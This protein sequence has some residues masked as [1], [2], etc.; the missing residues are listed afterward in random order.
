MPGST[1]S[2]PLLRPGGGLAPRRKS[3]L[4]ELD[5]ALLSETS[6]YQPVVSR[7]FQ[8]KEGGAETFPSG[9]CLGTSDPEEKA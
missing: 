7:Q 8:T 3:S 2:A 4:A 6:C 9:L 1:A 5:V